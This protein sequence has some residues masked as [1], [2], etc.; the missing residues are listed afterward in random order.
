MKKYIVLCAAAAV[1]LL[2]V[3]MIARPH[4]DSTPSDTEGTTATDP[5]NTPTQGATDATNA[6]TSATEGSEENSTQEATGGSSGE[7]STTPTSPSTQTPAVTPDTPPAEQPTP[8]P[9]TPT[10][11]STEPGDYTLMLNKSSLS[12]K[13]G[14]NHTLT[15]TYTGSKSLTWSSTNPSIATVSNGK[16]TAKAVGTV[17]VKVSDGV[18]KAQCVITITNAESPEEVNLTLSPASLNLNVGSTGTLTASYNGTGTLTW[19]SSN[20]AIVTV[21]NGKVTAKAAGTAKVTVSDGNKSATCSITVTAPATT[22]TFK[23]NTKS[24]TTIT[25]GTTFQIDY[26]YSGNKSELSWYSGNTSALTVDNNGLVTAKAKGSAIIEV[27]NGEKT[28]RITINVEDARPA[29]TSFVYSNQNAPLYDGVTKYAG[30]YMTFKVNVQPDASNPNI[31]VTS[32]NTSAVSVSWKLNSS[33]INEVTLNFNGAGTATVTIA[34]ADGAYSQS[35]TIT[36]KSG[37][38]CNPGGGQLTPE[39]FV[40]A[41]NGVVRANGMST[42]GMPSGYLV[43]TLSPSELTWAK[44]KREAEGG[45]HSWWKIGYRTMVLTYEGTDENGNYIFYERGC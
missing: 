43:L 42:S 30:D 28:W 33:D 24:K 2:A 32:N 16:V 40:N 4:T 26:T 12:M 19:S 11:E 36:V 3:F 7:G 9:N 21:S 25:A 45:F 44:A 5:V 1:L 14:E 17:T 31:T 37:Y 18:K 34:S 20:T 10:T 6:T 15:A 23:F 38:D 27:T 22:K 35:Y 8:P 39:Q 41:Y 13:V 29:A